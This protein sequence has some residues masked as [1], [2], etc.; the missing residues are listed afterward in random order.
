MAV[1]LTVAVSVLVAVLVALDAY[2]RRSH[3]W[4]A[5]A[6]ELGAHLT[7]DEWLEG[8]SLVRTRMTRAA[9]IEAPAAVAGRR[10]TSP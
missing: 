5:T 8:G 7:G 2:E 4:G 9:W 10:N 6:E 3:D 1:L